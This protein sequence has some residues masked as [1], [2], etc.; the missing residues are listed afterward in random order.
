MNY[1]LDLILL[2]VFFVVVL[3]SYLRGFAKSA[4]RLISVVSSS[5]ISYLFGSKLGRLLLLEFW[6]E[7]LPEFE[8]PE[9]LADICGYLG[10][11]VIA[12]I[13]TGL[14]GIVVKKAAKT[15][16]LSNLDSILGLIFGAV[17]GL[18]YVSVICI[19]VSL[20]VEL[21]LSTATVDYIK[22][23]A[24]DSYIFRFFCDIAP[25]EYVNITAVFSSAINK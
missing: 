1:V 22:S 21:K 11:F 5:V 24:E 13:G 4:W 23:I 7:K 25:F 20:I 15:E 10:L 12:M 18:I 3:I 17:M 2:L 9:L 6:K 19:A 14:L 16:A 8:S